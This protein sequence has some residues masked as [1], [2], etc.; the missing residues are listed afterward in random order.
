MP[1]GGDHAT[2]FALDVREMFQA[3]AATPAAFRATLDRY[4]GVKR[5][6][7][8]TLDFADG[9]AARWDQADQAWHL[10]PAD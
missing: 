7:G 5:T 6:D 4:G 10:N 3:G 2:N 9:S 1:T 8:V